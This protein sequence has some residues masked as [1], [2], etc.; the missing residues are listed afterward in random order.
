VQ[1]YKV[2]PM[3]RSLRRTTNSRM[4]E[5][6]AGGPFVVEEMPDRSQLPSSRLEHAIDRLFPRGLACS[7]SSSSSSTPEDSLAPAPPSSERRV[8]FQS[9]SRSSQSDSSSS[10]TPEESPTPAPPSS[11]PLGAP[12]S[13]PEAPR[14]VEASGQFNFLDAFYAINPHRTAVIS[15]EKSPVLANEVPCPFYLLLR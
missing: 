4:L 6:A 11:E 13:S 10:S 12:Q 15:S 2:V 1:S 5:D 3:A 9:S 7:S 8:A 14:T